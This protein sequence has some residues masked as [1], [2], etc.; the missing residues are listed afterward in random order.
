[1]RAVELHHLRCFVAVAEE[2]N[3]G[4]ASERLH[5]TPSPVSR[6][7]RELEHELGGVLFVRGYHHVELTPLG[8][9]LVSRA[10]RIVNDAD[11]LKAHAR[12]VAAADQPRPVRLGVTTLCPLAVIDSF[13]ELVERALSGNRVEVETAPTSTLLPSLDDG[14]LDLALVQLPLG[15]PQLSTMVLAQ[16]AVYVV[17]RQD[18]PLADRD[19]LRLSE[20]SGRT[21]FLNS[22]RVE[23]V[24]MAAMISNLQAR[25]VRDLVELPEFDHVKLAAHI[26]QNGGLALSVHPDTGGY[27]RIYA[28]PAFRIVPLTDKGFKFSVGAAWRTATDDD[29]VGEVV[30]VLQDHWS[31]PEP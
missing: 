21:M 6:A 31:P 10:R 12:E 23:P 17:M 30:T 27:A 20:L 7:I 22:T 4:R 3:F 2:L 13:V 16:Y 25:G 5:L 29:L 28:D 26:R 9:E 8:R 19:Q 24:A 1:M 14:D 18:D 11:R 15:Q